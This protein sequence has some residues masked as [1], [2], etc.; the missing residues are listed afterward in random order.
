MTV[1]EWMSASPAVIAPSTS[2]L[3]AWDL[4]QR[5]RVRHFPVVEGERLLGIVTDRDIRLN[6][7]PSTSNPAVQEIRALLA[8]VAVAEIMTRD[9]I[10]IEP[11]QPIEHAAAVMLACK[12]RSLPVVADGRLAGILT[13]TDVLR[14]V[15]GSRS[16][17]TDRPADARA[18]A[19]ARG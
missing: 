19:P 1:R 6:L 3:E 4:M 17:P 15:V 16:A 10:T 18:P 2:V 5:W 14:A 11:D 13:E 8:K 9:V 12:I 7:P